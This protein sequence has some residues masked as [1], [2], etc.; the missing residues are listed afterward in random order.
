MKSSWTG[1]RPSAAAVASW[2]TMVMSSPFPSAQGWHERA[3]GATDSDG[4]RNWSPDPAPDFRAGPGHDQHEYRCGGQA[5]DDRRATLGPDSHLVRRV[6]DRPRRD[7]RDHGS[8]H[9]PEVPPLL[10]RIAG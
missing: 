7:D 3:L 8:D 4:G 5:A 6:H 1:I 10:G 2:S 9:H